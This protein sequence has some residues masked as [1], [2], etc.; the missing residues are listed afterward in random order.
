MRASLNDLELVHDG[1][2]LIIE[3]LSR[4]DYSPFSPSIINVDEFVSRAQKESMLP[5][6]DV[7]ICA[8]EDCIKGG[9]EAM[10]SHIIEMIDSAILSTNSLIN[11][12]NT[13][14][15]GPEGKQGYFWFTVETNKKPWRQIF[16]HTVT[17][18]QDLL[19][20]W[21]TSALICTEVHN[22]GANIPS[23]FENISNFLDFPKYDF[24]RLSR[25]KDIQ[26]LKSSFNR[27]IT[28]SISRDIK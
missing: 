22:K 11:L 12:T 17:M 27:D 24:N 19:S 23:L 25:K 18:W 28:Y 5:K 1:V 10:F 3:T 14:I 16:S 20:Y 8:R 9:Y 4:G 7:V 21:M 6:S 15:D 26:K 2:N 13:M